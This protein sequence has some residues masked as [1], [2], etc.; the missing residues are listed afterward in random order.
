MPVAEDE[1][2]RGF[3]GL[4]GLVSDLNLSRITQATEAPSTSRGGSGSSASSQPNP[5]QRPAPPPSRNRDY[6]RWPQ[7]ALII[8]GCVLIAVLV[9]NSNDNKPSGGNSTVQSP[10]N[11]GVSTTPSQTVRTASPVESIPAVGSDRTLTGSELTYCVSQDARITAVQPQVNRR[12]DREID[13]FNEL[14]ADFN[15][16]C[17]NFRYYEKEM[18]QVRALVEARHDEIANQAQVWLANWRKGKG[19]SN[20][21]PTSSSGRPASV[22]NSPNSPGHPPQKAN[23]SEYAN[24]MLKPQDNVP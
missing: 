14:I 6:G 13:G 5:Q 12:S 2:A 4:E 10:T 20:S 17:S 1:K 8:G 16:R 19:H 21:G 9:S 7:A 22:P 11:T 23:D 3:R 24:P 15:S 18:T